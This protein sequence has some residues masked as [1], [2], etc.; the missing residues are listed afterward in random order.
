MHPAILEAYTDGSLF[1]ALKSCSGV[2]REEA[3]VMNVV[4]SYVKKM[5]EQQD[6]TANLQEIPT[7]QFAAACES[8]RVGSSKDPRSYP[9]ARTHSGYSTS[10]R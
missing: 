9:S 4:T 10:E 6:L 8:R 1:D 3:C 7:P 5:A 2:R